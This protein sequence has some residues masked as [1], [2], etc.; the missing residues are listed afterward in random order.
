MFFSMGKLDYIP[1]LTGATT[2]FTWCAQIVLALGQ[3]GVYNHVSKG[4]DPLDLEEFASAKPVPVDPNALTTNEKKQILDWIKEDAIAKDILCRHLLPSILR[5]IPQKCSTTACK[6]WKILHS[7]YAHDDLASKHAVCERIL[8]LQMSGEKDTK[9]YLGEHDVLHRDLIQMGA[10]YTDDEAIFSLLKGLP[11][12]GTWPAFKLLLQSSMQS[13]PS[14]AASSVLAPSTSTV[15]TSASA[16]VSSVS[17][18]LS[19]GNATFESVL[20]RIAVEAHR[21]LMESPSATL[22]GS[23]YVNVTQPVQSIHPEIN[24]ATGLKW[25][26]NNPSSTY[27]NTPLANGGLCGTSNHD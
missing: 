14:T 13:S 1:K 24:P 5:L 7:H 4:T 8:S 10:N 25:T 16:L 26:C 2:F 15:P 3:E 18:M 12:T 17:A 20:T 9:C 19:T 23:E 6:A 21:L 11:H 22:V 27:C